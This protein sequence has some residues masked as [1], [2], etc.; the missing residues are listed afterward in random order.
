MRIKTFLEESITDLLFSAVKGFWEA[1][2]KKE[3]FIEEIHDLLMSVEKRL[4]DRMKSD[5]MF[6]D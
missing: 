6:V 1:P 5:E 4:Q 2:I 3:A